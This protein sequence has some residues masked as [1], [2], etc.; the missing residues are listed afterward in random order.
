M[1]CKKL[2]VSWHHGTYTRDKP[3]DDKYRVKFPVQ[4]IQ[5]ILCFQ[6]CEL[7]FEYVNS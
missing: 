7:Y 5:C 2:D 4:I 3:A 1:F 6:A